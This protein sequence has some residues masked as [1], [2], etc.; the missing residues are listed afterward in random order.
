MSTYDGHL[1]EPPAAFIAEQ[2]RA[3][4]ERLPFS[5]TQ[6]FTDASRGFVGK[7]ETGVVRAGDGRVVWDSDSYSF[8]QG[9]APE[10]ANPSLWRQSTLVAKHGLFEV[11]E[12]IYQVRGIDLSNTTFIEGRTGV[13]VIDPLLTKETGAAA[14]AL[15]RKY[16]GDRPVTGMIYSP[17]H[18]D[19]F[20]GVKGMISEEDA[21]SGKVPILAPAG[22]VEHAVSE[23]VYAGTAMAR[24]AGY[25][26]GAS[27]ARGPQGQIGAGLGQTTSTGLVT[28]IPP[29]TEIT[30]TGQEEVI[31][32]VPVVFQLAP[33]TEA[34]AEMH[35]FFP[36]FGTPVSAASPDLVTV[37]SPSMLFD[38]LAV[39]ID[40]PRAWNE[41]LTIDI[42][43]TDTGNT[44]RLELR[45][46]V[47]THTSAPQP[48]TSDAT[49]T[50]TQAALPAIALAP[51]TATSLASAGI[52]IGG[53]P[54]ALE[55]LAAV[56]DAPD[57]GFAI[58]TAEKE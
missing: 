33:G 17:S 53:N 38:A 16:R 21:A 12:G 49:L 11:I 34:P 9:E 46:G 3:L 20:G 13:I 18:V 52:K 31:D 40:G 32:G 35:F 36:T 58:V 19:H 39:R 22:F 26:Y 30:K 14:L 4:R 27:L 1:T 47:L 42:H 45:N 5:D 10:C 7:L 55:R 25:M 6:D 8:L 28:L 56:L 37:L 23:N 2:H 41:H 29:T 51:M 44:Y 54:A 57:P 48:S 43:L 24:R 50:T 15:F